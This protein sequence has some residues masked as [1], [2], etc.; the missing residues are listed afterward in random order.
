MKKDEQA[1]KK[2]VEQFKQEKEG[3]DY[4]LMAMQAIRK[5]KKVN[6]V[7]A[8]QIEKV[9]Q[10]IRDHGFVVTWTIPKIINS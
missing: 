7:T 1:W 10:Y 3:T 5:C 4:T 2:A 9:A 8:E 6:V